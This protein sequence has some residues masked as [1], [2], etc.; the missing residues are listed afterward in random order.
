M[1]WLQ[2]SQTELWVCGIVLKALF[3]SGV[4]ESYILGLT[5]ASA[6]QIP[7]T[8]LVPAN[9]SAHGGRAASKL[10]GVVKVLTK[11]EDASSEN[12]CLPNWNFFIFLYQTWYE[13]CSAVT[14]KTKRNTSS[15][16]DNLCQHPEL[17]NNITVGCEFCTMR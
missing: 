14:V 11:R 3:L 9:E 4:K 1:G 12:D 17:H 16:P 7:A 6:S 8:P 10:S 2:N 13:R 5:Q 15:K